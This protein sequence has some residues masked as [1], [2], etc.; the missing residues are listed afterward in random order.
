MGWGQ[1]EFPGGL[2]NQAK[3]RI[4]AMEVITE[5]GFSERGDIV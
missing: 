2:K 5:S 1:E 4:S 3:D